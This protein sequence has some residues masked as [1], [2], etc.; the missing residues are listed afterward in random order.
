[1]DENLENNNC[2]K[3]KRV[4]SYD[5]LLGHIRKT[6]YGPAEC[7]PPRLRRYRVMN[8]SEYAAYNKK[9][10]ETGGYDVDGCSGSIPGGI[11]PVLP[12]SCDWKPAEMAAQFAILKQAEDGGIPLEYKQLL[13]VNIQAVS[14]TMYYLTFTACDTRD[15]REKIFNA[16]VLFAVHDLEL[17]LKEFKVDDDPNKSAE[18]MRNEVEGMLEKISVF[19]KENP[20]L[21][22]NLPPRPRAPEPSDNRKLLGVHVVP[23]KGELATIGFRIFLKEIR[24]QN[25]TWKYAKARKAASK[26]WKSFFLG[27]KVPYLSKAQKQFFRK[28]TASLNLEGIMPRSYYADSS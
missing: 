20:H 16:K 26:K 14:G 4:D 9:V 6:V 12:I 18:K 23:K 5:A 8:R 22:P 19:R 17:H 25:P 27:Q 10:D 7:L 3:S 11:S 15:G 28:M 2:N 13:K 24:C 1:M 21:F